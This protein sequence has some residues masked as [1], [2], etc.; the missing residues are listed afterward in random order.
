MNLLFICSGN[1]WRSPTAEKIYAN[2]PRVKVRSAGTSRSAEHTVNIH[3]IRWAEIIVVME[4]QH[5]QRLS[6]TFQQSLEHK[7]IHVLDI[8]DDFGFMDDELIDWIRDM[9]EPI[10]EEARHA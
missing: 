9:V 5:K 6:A 4:Y 1:K 8:P 7:P 2:D 3:D 10:I